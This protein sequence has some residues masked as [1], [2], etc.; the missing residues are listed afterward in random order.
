MT[1]ETAEA[2][3]GTGEGAA[4]PAA[5][6]APTAGAE[7]LFAPAAPAADGGDGGKAAE[8]GKS[9]GPAWWEA[10][11]V[12]ISRDKA[13]PKELSDAEWIA[14][15]KYG[16]P[17]D[18]VKAHRALEG[19]LGADKIVLPKGPDDVEGMKALHKALGVPET[20]DG[21]QLK[22]A[23][24]YDEGFVKS[25]QEQAH[26]AGMP[27]QAAQQLV[28]WFEQTTAADAAASAETAGKVL[29]AEWKD[30]YQQ[31][32]DVARQGME[33]LGL[34]PEDLNS[35]AVGYGLDRVMLLMNR[36]GRGTAEDNGLPGSGGG[37]AA[38]TAETV[39]SRKAEIINSPELRDK[40]SKGDKA[41]SQEWDA[42]AKF[43]ADQMAQR[44]GGGVPP[45]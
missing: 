37:G 16:S 42:I 2:G 9:E 13:D 19:K 22:L 20:P 17:G 5:P 40:L 3:Q 14:N 24:G 41:L 38:M 45:R 44:F 34:T 31:Q 33:R 12:G 25:F 28:D 27:P 10:E 43:E 11:N 21:Y 39:A 35:M 26:K 4:P 29:K 6:A 7:A 36:I 32:L 8:A 30:G 18:L 1:M 23:D 15:K